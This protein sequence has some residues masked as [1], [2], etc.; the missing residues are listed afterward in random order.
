MIFDLQGRK[1]IDDRCDIIVIGAGTVGLPTSVLLARET[2][3][4]VVCLES[5]GHRQAGDTHPLNT[6]IHLANVHD[7]A[8]R[9]RYRCFGGT[10]TRWGGVLLPFQDADVD[11]AHWPIPSSELAA[12]VPK[13]ESFFGLEPGPY[14]D[15]AF[16][17]DLGGT[18]VNR[19]AKR[20][21]FKKRNVTDL[22]GK[23][24]WELPNLAVW[25]NAT[26][27]EIRARP[28]GSDVAVLARSM[29]GDSIRLAAP[30]L[31]IAAGAIETTRLA[32]LI[33]RQNGGVISDRSPSLGRYFSDHVSVN[34]A[35][36][37]PKH[38]KDLNRT[39]GFRF[40]TVGGL[41]PIRFEL[42]P[43]AEARTRLPPSYSYLDFEV[44]RLSSFDALRELFRH[45]QSHK[46]PTART[47]TNVLKE[48]PWLA[49]AAWWR[50]FEHRL[51]Y[52]RDCRLFINVAIEQLSNAA[53]TIALSNSAVDPLGVPLAE[54]DWRIGDAD[55][56]RFLDSVEA[57]RT[58]WE[59]C[60]LSA[61]GEWKAFPREELMQTV[62][63]SGGVLHPTGSTRMAADADTGVVDRDLRMFALPQIQLLATSVL[64]TGGGAN[65]TM[66]LLMLM[67]RCVEQFVRNAK[68]ASARG[69]HAGVDYR[70]MSWAA[71][72]A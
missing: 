69:P 38:P 29:A 27:T 20:P 19:L 42:A 6:V 24:S 70:T 58:T 52:P 43:D 31:V 57:F 64:P 63:S 45:L 65:P 35:E 18:H 55:V 30:R 16:P 36:I 56:E 59:Q 14:E 3:C 26:V 50:L 28:D 60:G 39:L 72:Q 10:S 46:L 9:G 47:Y 49:R 61:L 22:V 13:V 37:I 21:P 5:G 32:L 8:G 25:L 15:E 12:F 44:I 68:N 51:L 53:N 1:N 54:I 71:R 33:D 4:R 7:G 41:R 48:I 34:V 40:D 11:Q 17:F 23:A 62:R 66:M 2:G 67:F